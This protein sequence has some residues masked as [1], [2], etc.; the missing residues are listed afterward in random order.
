MLCRN[1]R[2]YVGDVRYELFFRSAPGMVADYPVDAQESRAH[3]PTAAHHHQG[4]DG[5]ISRLQAWPDQDVRA[6]GHVR[7]ALD[8]FRGDVGKNG[9]IDLEFAVD[10]NV[11]PALA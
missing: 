7:V 4:L 2:A 9:G 10:E 3:Q 5:Q 1:L 11:G 8:L 6:T